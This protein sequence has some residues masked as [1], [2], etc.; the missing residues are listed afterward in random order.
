MD[1]QVKQKELRGRLNAPND[2]DVV[3]EIN[4]RGRTTRIR[5]FSG[6]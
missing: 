3:L 1:S 4:E 5:F 2:V 6:Q